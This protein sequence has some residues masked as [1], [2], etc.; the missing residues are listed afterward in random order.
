MDDQDEK[1]GKNSFRQNGEENQSQIR[2]NRPPKKVTIDQ[3]LTEADKDKRDQKYT[4]YVKDVTPT[5]S[6]AK[7]IINAFWVGGMICTIG[8]AFTNWYK[9]MGQSKENAALCTVITLILISVVLTGLQWYQ[10]IAK[11]GGAG[12]VVPIT[13]FAN[14]VAS[15]AV[16][17]KSEGQ[18]FGI[19]CKIFTIAGP[20]ILYGIVI[21]WALGMIYWLC[22]WMG[23]L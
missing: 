20:V 22:Q 3:V 8:Q 4:Q 17:Y 15:P 21:S 13:G 12:T 14:S 5:Y 1:E 11:L 18:V 16:E 2:E 23:I 6:V 7:N 19:G 10:N 9:S